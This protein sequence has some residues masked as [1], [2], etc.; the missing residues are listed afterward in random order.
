MMIAAVPIAAA[1]E[2]A[3]ALAEAARDE[4]FRASRPRFQPFLGKFLIVLNEY[5]W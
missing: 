2:V 5:L 1:P 3:E 4:A